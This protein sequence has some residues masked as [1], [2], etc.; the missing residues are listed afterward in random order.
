MQKIT[1]RQ[2]TLPDEK[3]SI[4]ARILQSLPEWFGIPE[5]GS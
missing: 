1:V 5:V 2:M 3:E 4:A